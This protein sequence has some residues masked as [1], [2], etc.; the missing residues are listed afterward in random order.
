MR[1]WPHENAPTSGSTSSSSNLLLLPRCAASA[2]DV[3]NHR[4]LIFFKKKKVSVELVLMSRAFIWV[5]KP[6]IISSSQPTGCCCCGNILNMR[7]RDGDGRRM[8]SSD[9]VAQCLAPSPSP[10]TRVLRLILC[11]CVLFSRWLY[12]T[13]LYL[14]FQALLLLRHPPPIQELNLM[15]QCLHF[16][17]EFCLLSG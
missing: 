12:S 8:S 7:I 6:H 17:L 14:G 13:L 1:W 15:L 16:Y 2:V 3:L 10:P 4:Q 9:V 11:H 5:K